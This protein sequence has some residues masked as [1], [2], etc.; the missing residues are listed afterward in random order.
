MPG[1]F[2]K[3]VEMLTSALGVKDAKEKVTATA[4]TVKSGN[5][6]VDMLKKLG[7]GEKVE[8][9][10]ETAEKERASVFGEVMDS[11][12]YRFFPTLAKWVD[13]GKYLASRVGIIKRGPEGHALQ[14]EIE[15]VTAF[16]LIV[17][18]FMLKYL[19]D[20]FQKMELFHKMVDFW[21]LMP[22]ELK[23]AIK[24]ED[25]DPDDVISVMRIMNQDVAT[26]KVTYESVLDK[27]TGGVSGMIPDFIK[28][29]FLKDKKN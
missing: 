7:F 6:I 18:D 21:P 20:P 10:K 16:S 25:Y 2:D 12:F 19:T 29:D 22:D 1:L 3:G 11:G 13:M 28:P 4:E 9:V 27:V 24:K 8:K 17:P 5:F 15:T 26:G 14:H 23:Q